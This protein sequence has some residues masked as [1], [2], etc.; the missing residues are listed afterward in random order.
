M[1]SPRSTSFM[2]RSKY[3]RSLSA[4]FLLVCI[5]VFILISL[6]GVLL[7]TQYDRRNDLESLAARIGNQAARVTSAIARHEVQTNSSLAQDLI[8][9]IASDQAVLC[10]EYRV[11]GA[12]RLVAAIPPLGC[13]TLNT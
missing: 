4:R 11:T 8:A 3:F 12:N 2:P 9:S 1:R 6:V 5:P 10:V 7:L 13:S